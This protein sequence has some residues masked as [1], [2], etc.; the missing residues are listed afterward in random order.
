MNMLMDMIAQWRA[1]R[2]QVTDKPHEK[3][4]LSLQSNI[5]I[6]TLVR[7]HETLV[8]SI[9]NVEKILY[10]SEFDAID[11]DFTTA[12]LMDI[13][14]GAKGIKTID[15][16]AVLKDFESQKAEEEQFL[17]RVRVTLSAPGF[18]DNAPAHVVEEKKKKM[19]EVKAK[20]AK[21]DVEIQKIRMKHK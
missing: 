17:T 18:A 11:P 1:L 2:V 16:K 7:N 3:I 12:V 6:H 14:L 5:D 20:I 10:A 4:T 21:I 15:R 13:T 8:I 19:N 9:L